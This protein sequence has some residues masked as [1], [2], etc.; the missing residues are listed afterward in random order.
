MIAEHDI[1]ALT[2]PLPDHSLEV[3]DV[4]TVVMVHEGGAGYTV[5]FMN[6]LGATLAIAT[7]DAAAV[8]PIMEREIANVRRVA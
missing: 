2:E 6:F 5:E 7:V 3:G 8:R 1:V 4:G